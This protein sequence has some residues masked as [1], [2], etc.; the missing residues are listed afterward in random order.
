MTPRLKLSKKRPGSHKKPWRFET[1][2]YC[3]GCGKM[4]SARCPECYEE[5]KRKMKAHCSMR[6][7]QEYSEEAIAKLNHPEPVKPLYFCERKK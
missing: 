5:M 4:G 7:G 3:V 1:R 2:T 6:G